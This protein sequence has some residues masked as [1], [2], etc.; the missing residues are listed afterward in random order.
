MNDAV[1]T[2]EMRRTIVRTTVHSVRNALQVVYAR[3]SLNNAK[4]QTT[5]VNSAAGVTTVKVAQAPDAKVPYSVTDQ[6]VDGARLEAQLGTQEISSEV[7]RFAVDE[8]VRHVKSGGLYQICSL[9]WD[10]FLEA[11]GTVAYGYR[12][13]ETNQAVGII[14]YRA[15]QLMEDGRFTR[16]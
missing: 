10:N 7:F 14:Y 6:L 8:V 4:A 9:P 3:A 12:R 1:V 15:M 11:D 16:V 5:V 2:P 13:Y